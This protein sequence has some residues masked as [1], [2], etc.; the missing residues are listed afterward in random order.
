MKALL[1]DGSNQIYRAYHAMER[2]GGRLTAP[3]GT[4][5][6]ALHAFLQLLRK[7]IAD[8]APDHL[9]LAFDKSGDTFRHEIY[10]EYKAQRDAMPE[11]LQVQLQLAH[12][13]LAALQYPLLELE[14]FEADDIIATLTKQVV[15]AGG[16]VVILSSDKDLLQLVSDKVK[17][18]HPHPRSSPRRRGHHRGVRG[19]AAS[20]RRRPRYHGRQLRQHPRR[21]GHRREGRQGAHLEAR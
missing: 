15:A 17:L 19:A 7:T 4:P 3:D 16:E 5:T 2:S 14:S 21:E 12:E 8:H 20:G 1:V 6:G 10:P 18:F 9:A 11:D 13:A